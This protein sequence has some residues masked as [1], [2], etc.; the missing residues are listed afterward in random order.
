MTQLYA[1][2]EERASKTDVE[3]QVFENLA[4][5]L[6]AD[7]SALVLGDILRIQSNEFMARGQVFV[8]AQSE[9]GR[10]SIAMRLDARAIVKNP[11][12]VDNRVN[13]TLPESWSYDKG[14]VSEVVPATYDVLTLGSAAFS[15]APAG[16]TAAVVP[17]GIQPTTR[18]R[19]GRSDEV[20]TATDVQRFVGYIPPTPGV[21]IRENVVLEVQDG[22]GFFYVI[23]QVYSSGEVGV[24]GTVCL[25]TKGGN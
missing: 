23:E 14:K 21:F 18:A 5:Y 25:L 22:S 4:Y 3:D 2:V 11:V 9:P 24:V 16:A 10:G 17:I 13:S 6:K 7:D 12:D 15:W 19:P 20:P 8:F 1:L